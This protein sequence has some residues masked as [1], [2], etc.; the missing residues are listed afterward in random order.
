MKWVF[1][2]QT[3]KSL[4]LWL[5]RAVMILVIGS[6]FGFGFMVM[7]RTI[8]LV[9]LQQIESFSGTEE[10]QWV[11]SRA[12]NLV[13]SVFDQNQIEQWH[14]ATNPLGRLQWHLWLIPSG[15]SGFRDLTR[16]VLVILWGTGLILVL[17]IGISLPLGVSSAIYEMYF[18]RSK[19][20]KGLVLRWSAVLSALP[21]VLY[22]L[23]GFWLVT[24]LSQ[25]IPGIR[26]SLLAAGVT[27]GIYLLPGA[28]HSSYGTLAKID[29][30]YVALGH[31]LGASTW[32]ILKSL[33]LPRIWAPLLHR[34]L[35]FC[36]RAVGDA[37]ALLLVTSA[38]YVSKRP[39]DLVSPVMSLP[40]QLARWTLATWPGHLQLA[41]LVLVYLLGIMGLFRLLALWLRRIAQ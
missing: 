15:Q 40:V 12:W 1:S 24:W 21:P 19:L 6:I 7:N 14:L 29:P 35:G 25:W 41:T 34:Y 10:P 23:V 2:V 38:W 26:G 22:G 20:W 39:I 5:T 33:V 27:L 13:D 4:S 37:A 31:S 32:Y 18:S 3:S 30:G 9:S 36:I 17:A 8:G 11:I 16:S 28:I